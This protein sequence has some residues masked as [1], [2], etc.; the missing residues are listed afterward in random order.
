MKDTLIPLSVAFADADGEIV[1]ILDMEPCKADPCPV[2]DPGAPYRTALEANKGA[3]DAGASRQAT[4]S[5][6]R[7]ARSRLELRGPAA[8]RS[9]SGGRSS[10]T[11]SSTSRRCGSTTTRARSR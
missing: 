6:T 11:A 3:F 5:T 2:Y 9:T 7:R 10:R 4:A 8:S 1:T